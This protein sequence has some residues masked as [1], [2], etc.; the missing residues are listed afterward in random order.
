MVSATGFLS[1][2]L[3]INEGNNKL[4]ENI[5]EKAVKNNKLN[6]KLNTKIDTIHKLSNGK[7]KLISPEI[8][9]EF[10]LIV[11]AAPLEI[12]DLKFIDF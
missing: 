8:N 5:L 4:S 2:P 3:I 9:E 1:N 7:Y 10:D 12:S 6:L 11:I